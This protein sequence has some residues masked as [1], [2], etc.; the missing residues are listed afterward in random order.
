[1]INCQ[2]VLIVLA[3][4]DDEVLGCGGFIKLLTNK[5]KEIRIVILGE[6]SSCRWNLNMINSQKV[7]NAKLQRQKFAKKAFKILG[8][9]NYLFHELPCGRFDTIAL[10]DI[11]KIIENEIKSFKPDTIITHY[12]NDTNSDHRISFQATNIAT[13]PVDNLIKNILCCE[14]PSSTEWR[15][16]KVFKPNMFV[17]I[18]TTILKKIEAF[19]CYYETEGK[20]FP[21]PRSKEG[22]ETFAKYR[23]IQAGL[24]YAE[25]Y[26][27]IRTN[28]VI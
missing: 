12:E 11:V 28:V 26:S 22:L 2:K 18:E 7:T 27:I 3:H 10:I 23:G 8:V 5:G 15:M 25:A 1:M 4:P 13:R 20:P 16:S 19:N 6:G 24:S 9:K 21:F 17:D 14:I